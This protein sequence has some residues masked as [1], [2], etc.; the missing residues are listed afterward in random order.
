MGE[1]KCPP[2]RCLPSST[3]SKWSHSRVHNQKWSLLCVGA[4]AHSYLF[5]SGWLS[6]WST[7]NCLWIESPTWPRNRAWGKQPG[8]AGPDDGAD[9]TESQP[10]FLGPHTKVT[11]VSPEPR[12]LL[13]LNTNDANL[14]ICR[15]GPGT[16]TDVSAKKIKKIK[17]SSVTGAAVS[18]LCVN[19][20]SELNLKLVPALKITQ[21]FGEWMRGLTLFCLVFLSSQSGQLPA[22]V[23]SLQPTRA[24]THTRWKWP[25]SN[26]M[27]RPSS[28]PTV[29]THPPSKIKT[30]MCSAVYPE[31]FAKMRQWGTEDAVRSVLHASQ[32]R[33]VKS[34]SY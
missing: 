1:A 12:K 19:S 7:M 2:L 22:P 31:D 32:S 20:G 27:R 21:R 5:L 13:A 16:K 29:S 10:L 11:R 26:C 4:Q 9:R 25:P 34:R 28:H 14:W 23:I 17:D 30:Q 24:H 15:I 3:G 33:K 8:W 6:K 18:L